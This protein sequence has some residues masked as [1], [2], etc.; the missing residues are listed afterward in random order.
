MPSDGD[1]LFYFILIT[2]T[3]ICLHIAT[4]F[5]HSNRISLPILYLTALPVL[6]PFLLF[7][8]SQPKSGQF[9]VTLPGSNPVS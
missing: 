5:N 4:W 2:L 3:R 9:Y 8:L 1:F 7:F 6:L